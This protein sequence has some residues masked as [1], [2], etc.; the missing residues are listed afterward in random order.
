ME[1]YQVQR[2]FDEKKTGNVVMLLQ[3]G[4]D[5]SAKIKELISFLGSSN[6]R[7]KGS[8]IVDLREHRYAI[9]IIAILEKMFSISF[10]VK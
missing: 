1:G 4:C 5:I 10:R 9:Q 6:C 2:L 7:F 3:G 8:P